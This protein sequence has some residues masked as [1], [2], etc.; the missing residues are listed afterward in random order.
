MVRRGGAVTAEELIAFE[1]DIAREYD[2]GHIRAPVHLAGGNED[3][4]VK[5]AKEFRAGD[6]FFS[7]W[8]SHYH[9]LLAGIPPEKVK[10]AIMAGRSITLAWPEHRF[11]ASAIVAGCCPIAVGVAWQI[12]RTHGKE[13]VWC[14]LGDM[15]ASTGLA[16]ECFKYADAFDLPIRWVVEINGKSVCTDTRKTWNGFA[17]YLMMPPQKTTFYHYDLSWPHSGVGQR[18]NF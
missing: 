13:R 6:Y 8:R 4:L 16:H 9:A 14:F 12:K 1:A 17:D 10:A 18:I 15:A 5:I 3:Q 2:A 11:L 7:T